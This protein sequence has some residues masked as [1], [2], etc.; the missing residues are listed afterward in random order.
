[1]LRNITNGIQDYDDWK[2][3]NLNAIGWHY[4]IVVIE[5]S[6]SIQVILLTRHLTLYKLQNS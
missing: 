1:M 3:N 5:C 2:L 6:S 4:M